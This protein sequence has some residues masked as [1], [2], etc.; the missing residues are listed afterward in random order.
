VQD[1]PTVQ[2]ALRDAA[3]RLATAGV[4]SP[5]VDAELLLA[6]VLGVARSRLILLPSLPPAAVASFEAAVARRAAREPLQH[7]VRAAPFLGLSLAVGPGVFIPRPETEVLAQWGIDSLTDV[8]A[9]VVVDLCSGS[10]A[11]ALAVAAAY[12]QAWVYAVEVSPDALEW[13]ERNA[14]DYSNVEVVAGDIRSVSLPGLAGRVD[15]VVANPPYVPTTVGVPPEVRADPSLAVFAGPD[16]L[17]LIP[18]VADL[19]ATLLRPGG[20]IGVEHDESHAP[21][22]ADIVGRSFHDVAGLTDLA[23]RPRFT[24]GR[25]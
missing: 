13:L 15:L 21:E 2:S 11:L 24:T 3:A 14:S 18:A 7:I 16:G 17:D 4:A 20:R 5:R 19:A 1:R 12:P 8:C 6:W 25:R 10:G 9:P 23:G 22:V